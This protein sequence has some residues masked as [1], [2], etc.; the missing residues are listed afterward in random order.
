[1]ER[2]REVTEELRASLDNATDRET[3]T[4]VVFDTVTAGIVYYDPAGRILLSNETAISVLSLAG[5]PSISDVTDTPLVFAEDRVTRIPKERQFSWNGLHDGV[6]RDLATTTRW[7]GEGEAQRAVQLTAKA[8]R[9]ASGELM[10]TVLISQDVTLLADAIAARDDFLTTVSHELRTPLTSII[11]YVEVLEDTLADHSPNA[12]QAAELA[13]AFEIINRNTDRLLALITDL[14]TAAAEPVDVTRSSTDISSVVLAAVES[15]RSTAVAGGLVLTVASAPAIDLSIDAARIREVMDSVLSNAIKFT[16]TA[17]TVDV[18]VHSSTAGAR[19]T[20]R[21]SGLG[22]TADD[23]SHVFDRF[24]RSP[25]AKAANVA[26]V[27]LGLSTAKLFVERHNGTID[28][29]STLGVGTTV[30]VNLPR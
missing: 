26:G 12:A 24:F 19:I 4:R 1:E 27:G 16:P 28:I 13:S 8:V 14:L 15:A 3:T 20:V 29:D 7:I 30:T 17:G 6:A 25:A 23:Q 22:M 9:R 5:S 11:G 21:D 2:L 10:G 18:T